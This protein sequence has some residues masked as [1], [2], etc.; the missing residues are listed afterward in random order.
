[1]RS[2]PR[3]ACKV[4]RRRN[5]RNDIVQTFHSPNATIA[6]R[7]NTAPVANPSHIGFIR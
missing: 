6:K 7:S 1:M 5:D 2:N 4:R 3:A